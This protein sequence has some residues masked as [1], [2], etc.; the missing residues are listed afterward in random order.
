MWILVAYNIDTG[1]WRFWLNGDLGWMDVF[2]KATLVIGHNILGYDNLILKKLFDFDFPKSC[3]FHDTLIFSRVLNYRRFGDRGHALE[4]WGEKLGLPKIHFEDWGKYSEEMKVYCFR[5]VEINHKVYNKVLEEFFKLVNTNPL[6]ST[7]L[8]AEHAVARWCSL[9]YM[10]GWPFDMDKAL[11]L[12]I[13]LKKEMD[14]ATA[15]LEHKLGYR[16][17]ALDKCKGE[18]EIKAPRWVKT[19]HYHAHTANYFG[20]ETES[21]LEERPIV[22]PYVRTEMRPLKLSSSSDV[23]VFLFRNGW[24]PTEYNNKWDEELKRKVDTS[25]KITEDSLE[26]LGG[27]GKLYKEFLTASSRYGVLKGWIENTDENNLLHGDCKTIGTPSMRATHNLI[28]NVPAAE[29]KWGKEMRELFG[30]LPGW[31]LIGCDSASNQARGLAHFLGDEEYTNTLINGDIHTY[32]ANIIDKVIANMGINWTEALIKYDRIRI[33][34]HV[35]RFLEARG[36][37][38]AVYFR[39]GRK[40]ANKTIAK[41]KRAAAKRMLYAFLFGA[42]GKKLWSYA[43]GT[44]DSTNGNKLKSGFSKAVPGFKD[45][46]DKL[47]NIYGSTKK[48]GDGYIP[49]LAGNRI[50][51]DS[52]HKLLVY[53]LQSTEKITCSLAVM[54]IMERLEE[55][56]IPYIPLIMMHDEADFMVPDEY[57]AVAKEIGRQCFAD[58]PKM[59]EINIMDGGAKTGRNW[60]DIH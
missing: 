38:K 31:T 40:V 2:S 7:Y 11:K 26:F 36:I 5:D 45:L 46:M 50:Y 44:L 23:K 42:S 59:V 57:T 48:F 28:V 55:A 14:D 29:S 34:R 60:Y 53:L 20:V 16:A 27:D 8:K 30:S 35:I 58:G 12:E 47:E 41:T 4:V 3:S 49:S 54:L 43:L 9:A 25:P 52:F 18:I 1:E 51:V 22:G 33:S 21:G 13:A 39:S 24:E 15:E 10:H 56:E 19:G 6:I 17:V 37:E 32:N